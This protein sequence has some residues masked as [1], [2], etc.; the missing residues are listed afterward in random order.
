ME[1]NAGPSP[2]VSAAVL[3][4]LL[5]LS[6][7]SMHGYGIMKEV[8]RQSGRQ[9]RLGPGTLY[10]NL[11]KLIDDELVEDLPPDEDLDSKRTYRLT[12]SGATLLASELQR[13]ESVLRIGKKRLRV[14]QIEETA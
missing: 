11:R 2:P 14:L 4:I 5:A 9:Y 6:Q 13:L 10:D 8:E 12:R 3:H 1:K 7:R